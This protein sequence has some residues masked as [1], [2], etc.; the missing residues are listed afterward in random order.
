MFVLSVNLEPQRIVGQRLTGKKQREA[1][2][3]P[4]PLE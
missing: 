2:K 3:G 4:A 1:R